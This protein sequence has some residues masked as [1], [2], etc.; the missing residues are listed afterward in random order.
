MISYKFKYVGWAFFLTGLTLIVINQI[1]RIKIK[2][3][4]LAVHSSYI[5][6]KY[7]AIITTNI[8]EEITL[9]CFLA[10]FL[11]TIFSKEKVELKEYKTLREESWRIAIFLNSAMLAF[12]ILFI[13]GRGFAAVLI[14]NM[15]SIFVFYIAVFLV[16]K[17]RLKLNKE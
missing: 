9:I 2:I 11:L 17:A 12:S 10:G 3:P 7:F 6:T 5:Q 15:F 1:Q 4:V 16:K 8:F 14:L 13:Y